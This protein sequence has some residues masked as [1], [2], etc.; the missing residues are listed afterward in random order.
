MNIWQAWKD[1][2]RKKKVKQ[3]HLTAVYGAPEAVRTSALVELIKV[4]DPDAASAVVLEVSKYNAEGETVCVNAAQQVVASNLA[5]GLLPFRKV[6]VREREWNEAP[7]GGPKWVATKALAAAGDAASI[8]ELI[9]ALV[10]PYEEASQEAARWLSRLGELQWQARRKHGLRRIAESGDNRIMQALLYGITS[11]CYSDDDW[12][13]RAAE[14]LGTFGDR[15]VIEPLI[16]LLFKKQERLGSFE[17]M[18]IGPKGKLVDSVVGVLS[19]LGA[20]EEILELAEKGFRGAMRAL[21]DAGDGRSVDALIRCAS[22]HSTSGAEAAI[23]AMGKIGGKRVVGELVSIL[24]SGG[25]SRAMAA[26]K[27]LGGMDDPDAFAPLV[28]ALHYESR[29]PG[30]E[31]GLLV[32]L[33]A[34]EALGQLGESRAGPHLLKLAR[35]TR[36]GGVRHQAILAYDKL[37]LSPQTQEERVQYAFGRDQFDELTKELQMGVDAIQQ[38]VRSEVEA[39][40]KDGSDRER[41]TKAVAALGEVADHRGIDM[42]LRVI[43]FKHQVESVELEKPAAVHALAKI[44]ERTV[45]D[46][47]DKTLKAIA[48]LHD[49]KV[50]LAVTGMTDFR[51][52]A[53]EFSIPSFD[54]KNLDCSGVRRIATDELAR[55][56]GTA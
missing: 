18:D 7:G 50:S 48:S 38:A 22:G 54:R 44:L 41:L 53:E 55:R 21:I 4:A 5:E 45:G 36:R 9:S 2:R 27:V 3:L 20:T 19:D 47:D 37:G 35:T 51:D 26:A 13:A 14:A 33:A 8:P 17:S 52:G 40:G 16:K 10:S 32:V 28:E 56:Q 1:H 24:Q 49:S 30:Q 31:F 42:L 25:S 12:Q 29:R 11:G 43:T 39:L 46:V 15:S 23:E 6:L 34:I